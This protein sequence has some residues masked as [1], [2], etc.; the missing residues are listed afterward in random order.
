[1]FGVNQAIGAGSQSNS[2]SWASGGRLM[3]RADNMRILAVS[4]AC[5]GSVEAH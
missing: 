2:T 5:H 3:R 4:G 1:M